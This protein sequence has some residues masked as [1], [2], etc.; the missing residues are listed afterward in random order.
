MYGALLYCELP[1]SRTTACGE[2]DVA[3]SRTTVCGE[4][5]V[6]WSLTTLSDPVGMQAN[7]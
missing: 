6:A 7:W 2:W 1:Q 3:Q 4:G 5:D